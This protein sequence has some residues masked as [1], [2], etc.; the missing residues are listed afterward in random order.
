MHFICLNRFCATKLLRFSVQ[1]LITILD[2]WNSWQNPFQA[3]LQHLAK[4]LVATP[5]YVAHFGLELA[6]NST[7]TQVRWTEAQSSGCSSD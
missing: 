6:L 1:Q 3:C 2:R 4:S 7:Q 5:C